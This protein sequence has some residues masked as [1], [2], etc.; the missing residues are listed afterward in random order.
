MFASFIYN[1][2]IAA[3]RLAV[4]VVGFFNAKA[5]KLS[6]GERGALQTL[7]NAIHPGEKYIW[8]HAASL[9]EFEQ[10][11]PLI[12]AIRHNNPKQR[13]LLTFFSPSGYEVRKNYNEVDVVSYL[14]FDTPHNVVEFLDIVQ[15]QQAIFIKYEFWNNYLQ[16]L[17]KRNIPTYIISA[18]FRR[19]QMFFKGKNNFFARMLHCFTH[20]C[21]QDSNSVELLKSIGIAKVTVAGDTRFDRVM[22]IMQQ[23]RD[24]PLIARFANE[25][26]TWVVGSSW[27]KDEELYIPYFNNRPE[28]RLIIAP[29]EI[30]E[31]HLTHIEQMLKRPSLRLSQANET[32]IEQAECLIIDSFGL[33][34]SIYRYGKVAYIGGGFG[35]GIH[36]TLEAVVY[37]IPV[38][39]GPRYKKFHEACLM[40]QQG[41]A[42]PV[43]DA[44]DVEK[45]MDRLEHDPLYLQLLGQ[46]ATSFCN[47][48]AGATPRIYNDLFTSQS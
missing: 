30:H 19:S 44:N 15:P 38:L 8:I 42:F 6:Q 45:T 20:I 23:R 14:P 21:V 16:E 48:L 35:A 22:S 1:L 13:I 46:K 25:H 5:R 34:S 37:G 26:F 31:E 47:S 7:R 12:E 2:S 11:R 17:K 27:E 32:N 36:N 18:I 29:H 41:I 39:F 24:L 43:L 9:G 4:W 40:V 3:Y 28:Q 33:L 10:G